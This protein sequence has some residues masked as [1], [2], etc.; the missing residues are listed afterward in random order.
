MVTEEQRNHIDA[1]NNVVAERVISANKV[2]KTALRNVKERDE[3]LAAK[4]ESV[5]EISGKDVMQELKGLNDLIGDVLIE[6][7]KIGEECAF[8]IFVSSTLKH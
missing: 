1:L 4:L 6:T 3:R 7:R 5:N 2:T 8:G